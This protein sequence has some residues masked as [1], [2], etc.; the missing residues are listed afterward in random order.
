MVFGLYT[1]WIS[2][3]GRGR[4]YKYSVG[5]F[6]TV[7]LFRFFT[8]YTSVTIPNPVNVSI[9]P[10]SVAWFDTAITE[11]FMSYI[12]TSYLFNIETY[13]ASEN[14]PVISN[15]FSMILVP[16]QLFLLV[17]LPYG[18]VYYS[19]FLVL[20]TLCTCGTPYATV[21]LWW[22]TGRTFDK[23]LTLLLNLTLH[24]GW[25]RWILLVWFIC[26]SY[27]IHSLVCCLWTFSLNWV[28]PMLYLF[29]LRICRYL[30]A[31]IQFHSLD[32]PAW[33]FWL[34]LP[35]DFFFC[36]LTFLVSCSYTWIVVGAGIL[37][38]EY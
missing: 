3:A 16:F 26:L 38:C 25:I 22:W 11:S 2:S 7:Y 17:I 28:P 4:I 37:F 27:L 5:G 24:M 29:L 33:Y 14:L 35:S 30:P 32:W 13:F 31:F 18:R 8:F 6:G 21:L 23:I 1:L 12:F 36:F 34:H 19:L 20:L 15:E 9:H 10:F